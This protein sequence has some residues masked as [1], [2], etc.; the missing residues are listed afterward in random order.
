MESA[1]AMMSSTIRLRTA[2]LVPPVRLAG[3]AATYERG[4]ML[5]CDW[6]VFNSS[7]DHQLVLVHF[8]PCC[9]VELCLQ[10]S[11]IP[12]RVLH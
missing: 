10:R 4:K 6:L 9:L 12:Q 8:G 7:N 3:Y 2:D 11:D 1:E 5:R